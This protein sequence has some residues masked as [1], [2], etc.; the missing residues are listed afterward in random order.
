MTLSSFDAVVEG[1]HVLVTW[2]TVS[3]VNNLGFNLYRSDS[4]DGERVLLAYVPSQAPGSTSGAT[5]RYEDLAVTAGQTYW[6]WLEAIDL[7][8]TTTL[9]GP[10]SVVYQAPT[11]VTV[12]GVSASP[13]APLA[14]PGAL[15]VVIAG[16]AALSGGLLARRRKP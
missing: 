2:E 9:H 4:A 8:G 16:F 12:T 1:D 13:A 5:Y 14:A 11:A 7:N 10:V 6:Y 15:S 3:E